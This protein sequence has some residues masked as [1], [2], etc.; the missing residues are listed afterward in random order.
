VGR[1]RLASGARYRAAGEPQL[2]GGLAG[3]RFR[4]WTPGPG[5]VPESGRPHP[6]E[7]RR[8]ARSPAGRAPGG[9]SE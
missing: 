7:A 4:V 1:L 9:V 8:G 3:R 5:G 2:R 6:R